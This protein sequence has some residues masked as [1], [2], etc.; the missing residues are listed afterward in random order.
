MKRIGFLWLLAL[1]LFSTPAFAYDHFYPADSQYGQ[2][3]VAAQ[4]RSDHRPG[5]VDYISAIPPVVGGRDIRVGANP[6]H[7]RTIAE[8]DRMI[9]HNREYRLFSLPYRV[10]SRVQQRGG[11]WVD[12]WL[13]AGT[14]ILARLHQQQPEYLEWVAVDVAQCGNPVQGLVVREYYGRFTETR[15]E[16][17]E[18]PVEVPIEVPYPVEIPVYRD[19]GFYGG[20]GYCYSYVP[21]ISVG[22]GWGYGGYSS[23]TT[24]VIRDSYNS[25]TDNRQDNRQD[26]RRWSWRNQQTWNNQPCPTPTP[27]PTPCPGGQP[28]GRSTSDPLPTTTASSA[29]GSTTTAGTST[30]TSGS[31]GRRSGSIRSQPSGVISA[32]S[33]AQ[34]PRVTTRPTFTARP[35]TPLYTS[36]AKTGGGAK[37]R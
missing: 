22:F 29:T 21:T 32:P 3:R 36:P 13:P 24:T 15:T 26:N 6:V 4:P 28:G 33:Q 16:R 35:H 31:A 34:T 12:G 20:T 1:V 25:Y 7:P 10:Y 5:R 11:R 17:V 2:Y 37:R 19:Y 30:Y 8:L 18:V 14:T 27:T 23:Q 9:A